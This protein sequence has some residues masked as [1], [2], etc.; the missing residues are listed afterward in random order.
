MSFGI[1]LASAFVAR[2][3]MEYCGMRMR[4]KKDKMLAPKDWL[5]R[6]EFFLG[7]GLGLL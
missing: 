1:S 5:E 6:E 7:L 3:R 4:M 2:D